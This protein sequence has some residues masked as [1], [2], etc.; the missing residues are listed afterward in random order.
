MESKWIK[1]K[2]AS[3]SHHMWPFHVFNGCQISF[4]VTTL[5]L[6]PDVLSYTVCVCG[7]TPQRRP[8]F[9]RLI[10]LNIFAPADGFCLPSRISVSL[11]VCVNGGAYVGART[12]PCYS[13]LR[14]AQAGT[15]GKKPPFS[16][17]CAAEVQP[18]A[19]RASVKCAVI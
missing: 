6:C 13:G 2:V 7:R 11:L 3:P 18:G 14:Y 16:A 19:E 17:V 12:P 5:C 1:T 4:F 8:P 10:G 9:R 15:S